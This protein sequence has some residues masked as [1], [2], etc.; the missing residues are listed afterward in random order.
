[1]DQAQYSDE[2]DESE[3]SDASEEVVLTGKKALLATGGQ[4]TTT[5]VKKS[6][7][8]KSLADGDDA[9]QAATASTFFK[10]KQRVMLL[11]SRGINQR[12]RHFLK[13][14][15]A[16]LPHAK[17]DSKFDAKG[18]I[19]MLN[20]LAELNNCNNTLYLEIRKGQDL[21]MWLSKTPNGPSCK[22]LVQNLHTMDELKMT[23]N[24]LKGSRPLLSFDAQFDECAHLSVIKQLLIHNFGTPRGHRKSKPFHDHVFTF[25]I[26]DGRV[27]FRNFQIVP[28][29][30]SANSAKEK[31]DPPSLVEIGP[32]FVLN[33]IKV[34]DGSFCGQ[35]MYENPD[36]VSPNTIR[37][38]QK[39]AG[40]QKYVQRMKANQHK[41]LK[42]SEAHIPKTEMDI[43]DEVFRQ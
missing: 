40:S 4:S 43:V 41:A 2:F 25:S 32:R 10:N 18:D 21:Y 28:A 39:A 34:F 35:V 17:K 16:L 7:K 3:F 11:S 19:K 22:F 26:V 13:D 42:A 1:M 36:Y 15:E 9:Q 30:V 29:A 23:G 37:S 5:S 12:Q 24:C 20:E 38:M 8:K 33:P 27:W 14:L 6:D 31:K